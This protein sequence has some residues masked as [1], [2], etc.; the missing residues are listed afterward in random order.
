MANEAAKLVSEALLGEDYKTIFL[1]GKAYTI[2]APVTKVICQIVKEWSC[3]DF[4]SSKEQTLM[5][6]IAQIPKNRKPI[7]RGICRAIIGNDRFAIFKS[8]KLERELDGTTS[9]LNEAVT[10]TIEL[11]GAEDFFHCAL[12]C[13]SVTKTVAKPLS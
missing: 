7:I 3:I 9:E 5:S 10:A 1:N 6:V 8:W 2:H 12:S 13:E 11:M 4:N